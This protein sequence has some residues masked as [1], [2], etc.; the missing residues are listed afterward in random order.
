[1]KVQHFW[2]PEHFSKKKL[3]K[4]SFQFQI[5]QICYVP[6]FCVNANTC[7]E[8]SEGR[9]RILD[10]NIFIMPYSKTN[11]LDSQP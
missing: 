7:V 6:K 10:V 11:K 1:M 4:N 3:Y 8:G 2:K 5:F 9:S